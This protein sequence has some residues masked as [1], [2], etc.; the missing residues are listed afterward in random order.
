MDIR[1]KMIKGE[2]KIEPKFDA[3]S[4]HALVSQLN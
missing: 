2:L 1:D 3:A 4:V